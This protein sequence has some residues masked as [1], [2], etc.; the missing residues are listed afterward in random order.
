MKKILVLCLFVNLILVSCVNNIVNEPELKT[1]DTV[2]V[3]RYMGTWYEIASIPAWFQ[4]GLVGVKANYSLNE[5]G[6]VNVANSGYRDTLNGKEEFAYAKGWV[7][8]KNI[9][10]KL[11]VQFFW[12]FE[13]D[14]WIIDLGKDYEYAVVGEPSRKFLWILSRKPIMDDNIY[15]QIIDKLTRQNYS[16]SLLVKSIQPGSLNK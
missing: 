2:D 7:P 10:S 9:P 11:K 15:N 4:K 12:P 3:T 13:A 16:V 6:T 1:V 8:D 14:Y 5:D